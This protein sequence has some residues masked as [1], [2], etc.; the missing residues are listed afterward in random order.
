MMTHTT[1]NQ[2]DLTDVVRLTREA[3]RLCRLKY[4]SEW[5]WHLYQ[6]WEGRIDRASGLPVDKALDELDRLISLLRR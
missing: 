5:Q 4:S 6:S 2:R 1:P 3:H